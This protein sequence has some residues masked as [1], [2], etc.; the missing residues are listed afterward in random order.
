MSARVLQLL[1][2]ASADPADADLLGRFVATR[3]EA[4]FAELVR[5]H[6]PAVLRVCRRLAGPASADDA[7]QAVFLVLACRARAV[8]NAASVGS[9]LI[10]VA[11]RVARQMR[12][13]FAR[14]QRT[15]VRSQTASGGVDLL[16]PDL[17]LLTSELAA[18]LDDELTRL[19]EHLRG[20]VVLCHLHGR[21]HEQAAAELGGSVRTL[22]RRLD[23]AKAV[24]R[25]RLERRGVVPTVAAGLV[26]GVGTVAAVPP[27]LSRRAVEGVFEFL[28]GGGRHSPAAVV[29]KGVVGNMVN[30]KASV[31]VAA[32]AAVMIG[33]GVGWASD[34]APEQPPAASRPTPPA[35][36]PAA[37]PL[38][39][40]VWRAESKTPDGKA[41][42]GFAG[43][44]LVFVGN[45]M[46][47]VPNEPDMDGDASVFRFRL[48]AERPH[49]EFDLIRKEDGRES[50]HLGVYAIDGDV[51]RICLGEESV[52]ATTF[53]PG[54]KGLLLVARRVKELSAPAP[55]KPP[56][57]KPAPEKPAAA[58]PPPALWAKAGLA[59][60]DQPEDARFA[61]DVRCRELL[62][63]GR[64]IR[65][66]VLF[67]MTEYP[68]DMA[69]LDAQGY[70]VCRFLLTRSGPELGTPPLLSHVPY[71]GELFKRAPESPDRRL[72][73]FVILGAEGNTAESWDRA[74]KQMY[75]FD[76]VDALEAAW[77]ESLKA[78]PVRPAAKPEPGNLIP[79]AKLP[80]GRVEAVPLGEHA[81]AISS[82]I[83]RLPINLPESERDH[84]KQVQIYISRNEGTTWERTAEVGS[85]KTE[86]DFRVPADGLYWLSAV[87]VYH[88]GRIHPPRLTELQPTLKLL[89]DTTPPVVR[90][91]AAK[92]VGERIRVEWSVEE[93]NPAN[94]RPTLVWF[95]SRG[96]RDWDEV[97]VAPGQTHAEFDTKT[98]KPIE[99]AVVVKDRAGNVGV[100][101]AKVVE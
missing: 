64:G 36:A 38:H 12:R 63:G 49:R 37:N 76:S 61:Q 50:R 41:V 21:T 18:I 16:T 91:T 5:R 101:A 78:P 11:G 69:V 90:V 83:G 3:D 77:L 2:A 40:T 73:V 80:G 15:E 7:F 96:D 43:A 75:G 28:A 22:R 1:S 8:R 29:A 4:A 35:A 79:P 10:G 30:L 54:P 14:G 13:Q 82:Q 70:S 45:R 62:N 20:P 98:D 23:R 17:C 56:A 95:R 99:L 53:T 58:K 44:D 52:R 94:Y 88:D 51:L 34:P 32:A 68:N 42:E 6:G 66:R 27:E 33:L 97:E 31:L 84:V 25:A 19:P 47:V 59:A 85:E 26:A 9:W 93:A 55:A 87:R 72:E 71:L 67:R 48:G 65:L 100:S 24:L 60:L 89:V 92:R 46:L 57:A 86:A 39:L 74:A 81:Y